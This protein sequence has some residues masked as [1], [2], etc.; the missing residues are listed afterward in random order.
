MKKKIQDILKVYILI[1]STFLGSG[2][3][4]VISKA[5]EIQQPYGLKIVF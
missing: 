2:G 1:W 4:G 3:R 5:S